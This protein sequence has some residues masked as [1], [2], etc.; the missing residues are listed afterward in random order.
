[1]SLGRSHWAAVGLAES[2]VCWDAGSILAQH[3]GLS[4]QHCCSLSVDCT[5]DSD[6]IASLGTPYAVGQEKK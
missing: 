3:S 5:C 1:M 2:L 6:L 4:I